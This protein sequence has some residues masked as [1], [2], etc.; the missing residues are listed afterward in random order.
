M[1]VCAAAMCL[2]VCVYVRMCANGRASKTILVHTSR[3]DLKVI[4]RHREVFV[5]KQVP[6]TMVVYSPPPGA[7][8]QAIL[9]ERCL[10]QSSPPSHH[11]PPFTP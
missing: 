3:E 1:Y 2:C 6:V 4:V 9:G 10:N 11:N 7:T 8:T 5:H